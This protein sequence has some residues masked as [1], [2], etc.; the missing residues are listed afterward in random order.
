MGAD[1]T[2]EEDDTVECEEENVEGLTGGIVGGDEGVLAAGESNDNNQC[3]EDGETAED[4]SPNEDEADAG[5]VDG[6]LDVFV[7]FEA[8]IGVILPAAIVAELDEICFHHFYYNI[9]WAGCG[10]VL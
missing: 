10:K 5:A 1:D 2:N 6:Q 3:S 8:D 9:L 4:A 7:F